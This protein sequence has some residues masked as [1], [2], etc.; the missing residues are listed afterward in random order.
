MRWSIS[1]G[2]LTTLPIH[3]DRLADSRNTG[4][5]FFLGPSNEGS[6][7]L[8]VGTGNVTRPLHIYDTFFRPRLYTNDH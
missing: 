2:S 7:M 1:A 6:T 3:V 8:S 5:F 4:F